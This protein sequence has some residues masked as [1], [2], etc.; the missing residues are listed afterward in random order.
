MPFQLHHAT[1]SQLARTW[2]KA[3]RNLTLA[4]RL[5]KLF[6][7]ELWP[8]APTDFHYPLSVV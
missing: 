5:S 6:Y 8:N 1:P 4:P 3:N 7:L 2:L